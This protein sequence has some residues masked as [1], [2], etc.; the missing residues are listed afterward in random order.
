MDDLSFAEPTTKYDQN[1]PLSD[2]VA[3]SEP[4]HRFAKVPHAIVRDKRLG[5]EGLV[6]LCYRLCWGGD[7]ILIQTDVSAKKPDKPPVMTP[8]S[9]K[10]GLQQLKKANY[11]ARKQPKDGRYLKA[12]D[13]WSARLWPIDDLQAGRYVVVTEEFLRSPMDVKQKALM[14]FL[15]AHP[16][17]A[18]AREVLER[19]G[20]NKSTIGD[21]LK[22]LKESGQVKHDPDRHANGQV[23][24]H[25][26][27]TA[28]HH[29]RRQATSGKSTH[30]KSSDE[31][32]APADELASPGVSFPRS[33]VQACATA[34]E[35]THDFATDGFST[36]AQLTRYVGSPSTEGILSR[37]LFYASHADARAAPKQ[38]KR[39][40]RDWKLCPYFAELF[41]TGEEMPRVGDEVHVDA[42]RW[43]EALML[44]TKGRIMSAEHCHLL[45]PDALRQIGELAGYLGKHS[46][47]DEAVEL[48]LSGIVAKMTKGADFR[49]LGFIGEPLHQGAID[50]RMPTWAEPMFGHEPVSCA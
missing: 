45:E 14:I 46:G 49:N 18:L 36:D 35:A 37:T 16:G 44:H 32:H 27:F 4:S 42:T 28:E 9:F 25:R 12:E 29:A 3:S 8:G 6:L 15:M 22:P 31:G 38:R 11:L 5:P 48:I 47:L 20:V 41:R 13:S 26:Y 23:E 19:F 39:T 7:W 24:A 21:W 33:G 43:R 50:G 30:G 34:Q 40:L 2:D 17:G 1:E 10:R